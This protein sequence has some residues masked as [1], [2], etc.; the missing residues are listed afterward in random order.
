MRG[1][2]QKSGCVA[3]LLVKHPGDGDV[4][5]LQATDS[6]AQTEDAA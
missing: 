3:V 2:G 5:Q 4:K 6:H 1:I